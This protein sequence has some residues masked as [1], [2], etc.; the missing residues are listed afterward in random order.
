MTDDGRWVGIGDGVY[1]R[2][3]G[4]LD[5][6]LGLVIGARRCLVI[7]TGRDAVHGAAFAAAIREL[8]PLP[9]EVLVTHAHWDHFFG[10][11]AFT[12]CQVWAH[13]RCR[14]AIAADAEA[15]RAEWIRH[16]RE[17]G[18]PG[19]AADL[20]AARLELPTADVAERLELDLGGRAV[21]LCHP[22]RGHT[23]GDVV[24]H[25]PDAR[26]VFAGDLVEQGAPPSAG[27]DAVPAE[28]PGTLDAVLALRPEIVVPGH[29]EPVDAAFVARQRDELAL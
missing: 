6:T 28:W 10:T 8:T 1:A 19:F 22:G 16:Y 5:Q 12:P 27:P 4:E 7:D 24:A 26:V 21:V 13:P 11:A 15:Q 9:W 25:V 23:A 2:R 17:Q 20:A 14:E 18:K 29:G 3:H